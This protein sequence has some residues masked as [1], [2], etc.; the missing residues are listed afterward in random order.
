MEAACSEPF[1]IGDFVAAFRWG[2]A[3]VFSFGAFGLFASFLFS[4]FRA[5]GRG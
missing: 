2:F 1:V 3:A 5:V 4:S